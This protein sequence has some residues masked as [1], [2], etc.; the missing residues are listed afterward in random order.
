[1]K[2]TSLLFTS[3]LL[4]SFSAFA[5]PYAPAPENL[6][7]REGFQD[8]KFG[9]FI[10]WGAYSVLADGEWVMNNKKIPHKDYDKNYRSL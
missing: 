1:M 3:I 7:A 9:L 4:L 10:H 2:K 8:A 5:Q 6:K